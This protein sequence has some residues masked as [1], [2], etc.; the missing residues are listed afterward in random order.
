MSDEI[1]E[2]YHHQDFGLKRGTKAY[3]VFNP[4]PYILEVTIKGKCSA[5][6]GHGYS[7]WAAFR[8]A[9]DGK[10]RGKKESIHTC[11]GY[12]TTSIEKARKEVYDG[13]V[14]EQ[15]R[16]INNIGALNDEREYLQR[17]LDRG[18]A[19]VRVVKIQKKR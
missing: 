2:K 13:L 4:E 14:K 5:P 17:M 10:C 3:L 15:E 18:T 19:G 12:L 8:S 11:N 9:G 16:V 7:A 6:E 1:P